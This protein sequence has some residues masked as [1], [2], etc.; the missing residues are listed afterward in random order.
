MFYLHIP[1]CISS[2]PILLHVSNILLIT[3]IYYLLLL[4]L[5]LLLFLLSL[6]L[7]LL[8]LLSLSS[9]VIVFIITHEQVLHHFQGTD[10]ITFRE[11][12]LNEKLLFLCS[13]VI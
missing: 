13:A 12:I 11:E 9:I 6:L 5:L 8:F 10:L 3:I 2:F 4:L 1:Y 7:L